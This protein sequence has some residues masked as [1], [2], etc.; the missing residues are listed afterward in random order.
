MLP[1][2][3]GLLHVLK[4]SERVDYCKLTFKIAHIQQTKMLELDILNAEFLTAVNPMGQARDT[5]VY[6]YNR[7][8]RVLSCE[9]Q[10]VMS[11]TA[12]SN[13]NVIQRR[14]CARR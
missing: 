1:A 11:A 12:A 10:S 14:S 8:L 13:Q 6:A 9:L 2:P 5:E 3:F 4:R 7:C